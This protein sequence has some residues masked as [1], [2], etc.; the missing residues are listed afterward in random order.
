MLFMLMVAVMGYQTREPPCPRDKQMVHVKEIARC[1]VLLGVHMLNY[2][3]QYS[4][5]IH[6]N[7]K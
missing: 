4:K 5:N 2:C 7:E 1:Q 3:V 6:C